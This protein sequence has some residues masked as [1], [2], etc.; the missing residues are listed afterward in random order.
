MRCAERGRLH[1]SGPRD[2]D[3]ELVGLQLEEEVHG[4]GAA[5]G[6]QHRRA[7]T[8]AAAIAS[9]IARTL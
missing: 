5:V 3:A 8:A 4:R 7:A 9:T 2:R 1:R 6:P